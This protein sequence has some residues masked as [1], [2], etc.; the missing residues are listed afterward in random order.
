M[1]LRTYPYLHTTVSVTDL[2]TSQFSLHGIVVI[3]KYLSPYLNH[4]YKTYVSRYEYLK[5]FLIIVLEPV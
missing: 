2:S 5:P 1:I 4:P 3:T